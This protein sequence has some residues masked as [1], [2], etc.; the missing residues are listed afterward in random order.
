VLLFTGYCCSKEDDKYVA[1]SMHIVK[2]NGIK[3]LLRKHE[4]EEPMRRVM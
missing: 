4:Q 2:K 1:F 3:S